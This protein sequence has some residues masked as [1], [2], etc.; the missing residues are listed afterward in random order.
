MAIFDGIGGFYIMIRDIFRPANNA[1]DMTVAVWV[2]YLVDKWSWWALVFLIPSAVISS[3]IERRYWN[4]TTLV[5]KP[6]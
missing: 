1:F 2:I 6:E 3:M 4:A 5:D